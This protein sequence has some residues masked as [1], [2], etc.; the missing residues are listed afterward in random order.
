MNYISV[1]IKCLGCKFTFLLGNIQ[2]N[3]HFYW[4][5]FFKIH[6]FIWE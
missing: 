4:G 1:Y 2:D 6:I 5:I 3:L